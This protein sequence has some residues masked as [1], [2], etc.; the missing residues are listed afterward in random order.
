MEKRKISRSTGPS[1]GCHQRSCRICAHALRS[2][3]EQDFI[4]W[5]SPAQIARQ[6]QLR[7]R[8]TVY[9]HA[10]IVPCYDGSRKPGW[11]TLSYIRESLYRSS[12]T[13]AIANNPGENTGCREKS[14]H[15]TGSSAIIFTRAEAVARP[16]ISMRRPVSSLKIKTTDYY[17]R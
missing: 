3:I 17:F 15:V 8:S 14:S 16:S 9:R 13:T 4:S 7:D 10:L 11:C 5:Q 6:Y 2:E 12:Q 1:L